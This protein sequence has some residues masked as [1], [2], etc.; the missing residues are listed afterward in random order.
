MQ[1]DLETCP[2]PDA[3]ST[4][5]EP[6]S[7]VCKLEFFDEGHSRVRAITS[8]S[9][10]RRHG[11]HV[12]EDETWRL[13]TKLYART[14]W[15]FDLALGG[16]GCRHIQ[17]AR[18]RGWSSQLCLTPGRYLILTINVPRNWHQT[19]WSSASHNTFLV[20]SQ[21]LLERVRLRNI[22]EDDHESFLPALALFSDMSST[23]SQ[24]FIQFDE[25]S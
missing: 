13:W 6:T 5:V 12:L 14:F 4:P 23:I 18:P 24:C 16:Q 20:E 25:S 10:K 9:T 21:Q 7:V 22:I 8:Y 15:P 17:K 2:R 19:Q 3:I 1:N 11:P